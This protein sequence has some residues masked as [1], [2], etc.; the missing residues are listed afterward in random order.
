MT[1]NKYLTLS[2]SEIC[3]ILI[4]ATLISATQHVMPPVFAR[5]WEAECL[6]T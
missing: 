6:N 3:N 4:S 2:M 5:K 1:V